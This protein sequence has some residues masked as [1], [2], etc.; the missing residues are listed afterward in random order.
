M[1]TRLICGVILASTFVFGG[2]RTPAQDARIVI[3][4]RTVVDG[5]GGVMRDTRIVVE[6]SRI[7]AIDP[8]AS[9]VD[10][11]LGDAV[12]MPGWIDTHVHINWHLDAN[13]KSVN[14]GEKLEDAALYTEG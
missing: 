11:D 9:P 1:Q 10:Y 12:L 14:S 13:H 7:A 2:I 3:A 6:G 8:T 5:R 4:A